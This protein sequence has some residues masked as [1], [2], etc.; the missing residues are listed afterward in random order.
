MLAALD[1]DRVVGSAEIGGSLGDNE[2][3]ADLEITVLPEHRRQGVGRLLHDESVRRVRADSR[4]TVCGEVHV[5]AA[6]ADGDHAAYLFAT[7]LGF[8][9]VHLEDHLALLLPVDAD[10]L[11]ALR[12]SVADGR[13]T[14]TW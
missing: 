10:H 12:A 11:D 7:A 3:L 4:S 9:S 13:G 1:G 8:E 5:P 14:T 6:V 2:H